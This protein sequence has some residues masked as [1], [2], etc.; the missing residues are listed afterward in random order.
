MKKNRKNIIILAFVIILSIE[1]YIYFSKY[2]LV[3]YLTIP[4]SIVTSIFSLLLI[5]NILK[6]KKLKFFFSSIIVLLT[7]MFF[8]WEIILASLKSANEISQT[9]NI[10]KFE[11][12]SVSR[13]YNGP[14]PSFYTLKKVYCFGLIYKEMDISFPENFVNHGNK[15]ILKFVDVNMTFDLC[16]LKQLK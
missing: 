12:Q 11:I 14:E 9:W 13:Y 3:M 16:N 8:I 2:D 7:I 1:F 5:S 4:I 10:N 15:C 6:N